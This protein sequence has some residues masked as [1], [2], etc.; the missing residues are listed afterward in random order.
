MMKARITSLS[1]ERHI[2]VMR[3]ASKHCILGYTGRTDRVHIL[4]VHIT[5]LLWRVA[6]Y[7]LLEMLS[8]LPFPGID[9]KINLDSLCVSR[10]RSIREQIIVCPHAE[11]KSD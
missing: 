3:F 2:S 8:F 9:L 7:K 6:T 10:L 11:F 5:D 4:T 1:R